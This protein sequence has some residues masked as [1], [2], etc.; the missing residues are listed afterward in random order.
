VYDASLAVH[1]VA[2]IVGFGVTFSYPVIQFVAERRGLSAAATGLDTV[3]AIS[4]LVAVPAA[5]VV[6]AT[7]IYQL[8]SGPYSLADAWLAA[9]F[10]LYVAVMVVAIGY[11]APA[12]TRARDAARVGAAAAY[13]QAVRGTKI[14]GPCV[15][16][17]IAAIAVL[18]EVKPG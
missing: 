8:L 3:L 7:G 10:G 15:A 2:A 12:Y 5:L 6:G 1:V 9:G 11:L 17:A 18:M 13:E 16:A 14:V 4:R